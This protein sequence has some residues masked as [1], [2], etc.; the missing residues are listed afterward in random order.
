MATGKITKR[1]VD[2]LVPG[3]ADTFLWDDELRGFGL[4]ITPGGNRSY[5]YQYR[6][7]VGARKL[8]AGRSVRTVA[9][10]RRPVLAA[11]L[12]GW[13]IWSVVG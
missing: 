6:M 5:V 9:H 8:D 7:V 3:A 11:R 13:C 12:R 10:G 1:S 2:A 4:K